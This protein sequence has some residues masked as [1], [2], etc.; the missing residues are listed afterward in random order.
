MEHLIPE[1]WFAGLPQWAL[2]ALTALSIG[3][4]GKGADWLV[5]SASGLAYRLGISKVIVGATIVSLG[6][7]SPECAVSVMAAWSGEPGLA[8][9]NAIGSII[10][11]TGLIFGLGC[12]ITVL[13]ADRFVLSR[14]GWVQFGS[15][16]LL[17][18]VCYGA[19][20]ISGDGA[21]LGRPVGL[22]MLAL[23]VLY[24]YVSIR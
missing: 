17:A 24:L 15:G 7:T 21:T 19:F 9:G 12:L 18:A 6:T 3:V 2:L 23:L 5:D 11:D 22:L 4:L 13:P 10:A 8:L 20:V 14:Q 1:A 16:V